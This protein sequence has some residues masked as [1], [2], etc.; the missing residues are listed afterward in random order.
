MTTATWKIIE[1][2]KEKPQGQVWRVEDGHGRKG[3]FKFAYAT[4]WY[5]AGPIAGNEWIAKKFADKLGLPAADVELASVVDQGKTLPGIVSLPKTGVTLTNWS[6]L[7]D[8]VKHHMEDH[9]CHA[10]LL[11]GTIVFDAWLTNIDRASGKNIILYDGQAVCLEWYLIDHGYAL[12]GCPR[13]W[14]DHDLGSP[15][16]NDVWRFYHV[17]RGF[18]R[19]ATRGSIYRMVDRIQA[20]KDDE[21]RSIIKSVPDPL[22]DKQLQVK[23]ISLLLDRKQNL[24]NIMNSWLSY[25]GEKESSW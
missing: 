14:A 1:K 24:Y 13:K 7:P 9:V 16:W 3:F 23:T 4:Q 25:T 18:L 20:L 19:M 10:D 2:W 21:I 6:R 5:D 8:S 15:Y 11:T 12:Y 17:P 22:Y